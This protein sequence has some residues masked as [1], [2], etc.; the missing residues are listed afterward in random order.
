MVKINDYNR[1]VSL[2]TIPQNLHFYRTVVGLITTLVTAVPLLVKLFVEQQ[3]LLALAEEVYKRPKAAPQTKKLRK[4]DK[5]RDGLFQALLAIVRN[6]LKFSI[7]PLVKEAAETVLF[8]LENFANANY[9]EYEAA[10]ED[11]YNLVGDLLADNVKPLVILL[12]VLEEVMALK[13]KNEEFQSVY[14]ERFGE[15]H[16][17]KLEGTSGQLRDLMNAAFDK[18][19]KAITGLQFVLED[20]ADQQKLDAIVNEINTTI[21]QFT[22]ILDRHLGRKN[23]KGGNDFQ[24]PDITNPEVPGNPEPG[25]PGGGTENPDIENPPLPPFLPDFE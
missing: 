9:E 1:L 11:L 18:L 21:D 13:Q 7:D 17:H 14:E 3:R 22:L 25:E 4:L 23:K 15:R 20:P 2:L 12:N 19:C 16:V 6:K 10:T 5:E 24:L 8:L